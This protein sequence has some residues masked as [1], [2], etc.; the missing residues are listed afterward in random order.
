MTTYGSGETRT[1]EHAFRRDLPYNWAVGPYWTSKLSLH[2]V[3]LELSFL[4]IHYCQLRV[5]LYIFLLFFVLQFI[6][7]TDLLDRKRFEKNN[8]F[9]Y[10]TRNWDIIVK[11]KYSLFFFLIHTFYRSVRSVML[12]QKQCVEILFFS[13]IS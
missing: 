3:D 13:F 7:F 4:I 1:H 11:L 2:M 6:H 12:C 10:L 9:G 8:I 5:E